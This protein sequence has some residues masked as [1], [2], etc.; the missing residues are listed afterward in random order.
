MLIG[1]TS[2]IVTGGAS[3]LGGATARELAKRGATVFALDLPAA[4]TKDEPVAGIRY[5]AADVTD[6]D[7]VQAAVDTAAG[8]D[9]PLR[10]VVNCAGVGW[11]GR[12][13]GKQG[14]HD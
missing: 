9:A 7:Q 11:A 5:L 10:I 8:S 1:N 13:I 3:G 4:V 12:I 6:A 14:P 2:A